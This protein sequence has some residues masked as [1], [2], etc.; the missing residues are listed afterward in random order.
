MDRRKSRETSDK[1]VQ[2]YGN[3]L[4]VSIFICFPRFLMRM[5]S[6]V[7]KKAHLFFAFEVC[8]DANAALCCCPSWVKCELK[9]GGGG[10]KTGK[11][12]KQK[13]SPN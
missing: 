8:S 1:C 11:F 9:L 2:K 12:M 13:Q 10:D 7:F 3:V 4:M 5:I 6:L